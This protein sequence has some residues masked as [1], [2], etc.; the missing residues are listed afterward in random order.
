VARQ[1]K[2]ARASTEADSRRVAED[3]RETEW[4]APSF[5]KEIFL[6]NLR[7]DLVYPFP[8][9]DLER[10]EF[11]AFADRLER[12]LV[13]EVDSDRID[14]EGKIPSP[15]IERLAEMG[16]FG[17]K[18]PKEYGGLGLS[19]M[20][21]IRA[22]ELVTSKD[23]SLTAM[24]SAHQSIGVPQPLKLFGT[25]EQKRKYFPRLAKGAISAFALTEVDAGSDPANMRCTA[26]PTE[27]GKSFIINGEKLWCTNGTRAELFVVMA[28]T[29]DKVIDGKPRRQITAFIVEASMPGVEVVHRLRF[30]GLK[31]I[32]NGVIRFT[33]VKVPRENIL[34]D[35]G[36]GLK[37]ALVTLNT[38]RLTIPAGCA[39]AGKQMVSVARKWCNERVQ[40]GQPIG[41]HEAVAQKLAR[42][43]T[44]TFAMEA[45]AELSAAL[46]EK[47]GYDIR[48]EAALAKLYNTEAG[49]KIIDDTMQL[50]GGRGY[51][52][53]ESLSRRGEP[54]IPIERAMRDFRINLIF[55]GSSEIMRLFIAREAVD[56]H[57]KLAFNIVNPETTFKEKLSAMAK[58]TPF[59]LT[60]YPSRWLSPSRFKRYGEFGKLARHVRYIERA[61][62]H[63]GRSIFHAM[64]RFGPKLE[65]RQMVLFRAVDIGAELYAMS[66]ACVRAQMLAKQG[67]K[68]AVTLADAFCLEARDRI[69]LHFEHLFGPNDP[70]IYKVA[71][72][73]MRG[74]H[75]WL[76]QGIVSSS[77]AHTE[78]SRRTPVPPSAAGT[79]STPAKVGAP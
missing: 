79:R 32:E 54:A 59:Y 43:T 51:E 74:E 49:W 61:T 2:S 68:E 66:A 45:V 40:W 21:Y 78:K 14:R 29:P 75:A 69:K 28:R 9:A 38:G 63:L 7:L 35:E 20:S 25:E 24:L 19:Q 42:M 27:D 77:V 71:M 4:T 23:G 44:Y 70:A 1:S 50:R 5:L 22:I 17:I 73:V 57:F 26:T 3:A 72:E 15:V 16:A 18:I 58:A 46:Y 47:G 34:W 39:G 37:L 13:E 60:W 56:Y 55:E 10:P 53:A 65:R 6:G 33:N 62:R 31:A 41:K 30:M 8:E 48:L 64:V 12:F 52:M 11:R 67:R 76:E 36:K